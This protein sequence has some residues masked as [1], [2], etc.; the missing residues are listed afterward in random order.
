[1]L[2][3]LKPS[4]RMS[5]FNFCNTPDGVTSEIPIEKPLWDP[6][7]RPLN[8]KCKETTIS[9]HTVTS[10]LITGTQTYHRVETT[11]P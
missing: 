7:Q 6:I 1:M 3:F 11:G 8:K 10:H 2:T 5:C 4:K 9:Y